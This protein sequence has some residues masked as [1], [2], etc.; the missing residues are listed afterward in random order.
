[1]KELIKILDIMKEKNYKC[2]ID[3][4]TAEKR[5]EELGLP[6]HSLWR[7]SMKWDSTDYDLGVKCRNE[8]SN[9]LNAF[10]N[11]NIDMRLRKEK[12]ILEFIRNYLNS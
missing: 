8:I 1:M 4:E 3:Y 10:K 11:D 5:R 12:E 7:T 2:I 9:I 6:K